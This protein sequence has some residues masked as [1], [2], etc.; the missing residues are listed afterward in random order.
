M[1]LDIVERNALLQGL[2]T[3]SELIMFFDEKY[4]PMRRA[5]KLQIHHSILSN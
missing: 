2:A 3:S 4:M 5:G 1:P